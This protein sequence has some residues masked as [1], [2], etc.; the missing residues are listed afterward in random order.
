V[1]A[2]PSGRLRASAEED[3]RSAGCCGGA[4]NI[5]DMQTM[6][7]EASVIHGSPGGIVLPG[8]MRKFSAGIFG[9]LSWGRTRHQFSTDPAQSFP[10]E[11]TV[12]YPGRA[13]GSIRGLRGGSK[14]R[15]WRRPPEYTDC[16]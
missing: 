13:S 9:E 12:M 10:V 6:Q 15:S 16:G 4:P 2:V 11:A 1:G 14:P 8:Q 7:G 3:E 5:R